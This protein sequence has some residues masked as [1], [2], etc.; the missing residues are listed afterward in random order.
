MA[1][2]GDITTGPNRIVYVADHGPHV[3]EAGRRRER[4]RVRRGKGIE[5]RQRRDRVEPLPIDARGLCEAVD[6]HIRAGGA[7]R[8]TAR[9]G[10]GRFTA[11]EP[12]EQGLR[13]IW[14]LRPAA[15][16]GIGE[17]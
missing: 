8:F 6:P 10:A 12:F 3:T 5:A 11:V 17:G 1:V 14:E 2:A 7:S 13:F 15:I 16:S 9:A 4:D